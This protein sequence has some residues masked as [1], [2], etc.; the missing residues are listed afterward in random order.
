MYSNKLIEYI[1][2]SF[3]TDYSKMFDEIIDKK[4]FVKISNNSETYY[5]IRSE[6]FY[7]RTEYLEGYAF[8]DKYFITVPVGFES[9]TDTFTPD[10]GTT[11]GVIQHLPLESL[12]RSNDMLGAWDWHYALILIKAK[13]TLGDDVDKVEWIRENL[14]MMHIYSLSFQWVENNS[15]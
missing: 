2:A 14:K 10:S 9:N 12:L 13:E 3:F 15:I 11:I 5:T 8:V 1:P 7:I 4:K 6:D